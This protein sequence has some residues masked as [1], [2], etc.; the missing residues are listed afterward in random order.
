MRKGFTFLEVMI[1][2]TVLIVVVIIIYAAFD[3]SDKAYWTQVP[4]KEAQLKV[5]KLLEE[6]STETHESG[7]D[8]VWRADVAGESLP[9]NASR[10][11]VWASARNSSNQF[12]T[13][14]SFQPVWQRTLALVPL[15]EADGTLSLRRYSFSTTPPA[16]PT[17]TPRIVVT[18]GDLLVQWVDSGGNVVATSP[19]VARGTGVKALTALTGFT[20]TPVSTI[21]DSSGATVVV[22]LIQVQASCAGQTPKGAVTITAQTSIRGRN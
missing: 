17:C 9:A 8:F 2:S 19:T 3:S 18:T 7:L 14:V 22:D 6:T 21:T 20:V 10:A 13:N 5:Q 12:V 16:T 1:A 15:N 4:L 11:L